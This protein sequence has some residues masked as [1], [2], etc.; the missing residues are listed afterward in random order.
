MI[1]V[2][3]V[4]VHGL[5]YSVQLSMASSYSS[6]AINLAVLAIHQIIHC[7]LYVCLYGFC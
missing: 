3:L 7:C 4:N 5:I 1:F 2:C 6:I